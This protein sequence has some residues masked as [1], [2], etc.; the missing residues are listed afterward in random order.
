MATNRVKRTQ[1]GWTLVE[2]SLTLS[3]AGLLVMIVMPAFV[4]WGDRLHREMFLKGL[5]GD[6]RLAQ[7]EATLREVEVTVQVEKRQTTYVLRRGSQVWK[8]IQAPV[9]FRLQSNYPRDRLVF[10][11]TG[12]VR[13]YDAVAKSD[14][15]STAESG[16]FRERAAQ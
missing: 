14:G 5:A 10:R 6:I 8:R 12:Q 9:G 4:Q 13:R 15:G 11:R 7:R 16:C 3:L 2:L 1:G